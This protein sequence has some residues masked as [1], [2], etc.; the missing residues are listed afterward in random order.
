MTSGNVKQPLDKNMPWDENDG[1]EN[2]ND[3]IDA[4]YHNL[5]K[6]PQ[7][8][9]AE[10]QKKKAHDDGRNVLLLHCVAGLPRRHPRRHA[11]RR[12]QQQVRQCCRVAARCGFCG[13]ARCA[14]CQPD[15]YPCSGRS[16]AAPLERPRL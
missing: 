11:W 6:Y 15:T 1:S 9:E 12:V 7:E 4:F 13:S 10:S 16:H 8:Q 5:D 14:P 2:S 3:D